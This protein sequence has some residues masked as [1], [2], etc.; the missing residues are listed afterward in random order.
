MIPTTPSRAFKIASY[1]ADEEPQMAYDYCGE[2]LQE[3]GSIHTT[4]SHSLS[5]QSA[6]PLHLS[7]LSD[8]EPPHPSNRNRNIALLILGIATAILGVVAYKKLQK[9]P[10]PIQALP[11]TT[12][13]IVG[14]IRTT[15]TPH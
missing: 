10:P 9:T 1:I 12:P 8:D 4:E 6:E 2:V 3:L 14:T 15:V 7:A 5:T 13:R 11:R